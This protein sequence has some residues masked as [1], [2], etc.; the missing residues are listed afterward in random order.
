[1]YDNSYSSTRS[2]VIHA[3]D[4]HLDS[5]FLGLERYEGAPVEEIAGAT[6][7]AFENLVDFAL[8]EQAALL[9]LAGDIYDGDWPD[10]NTGLFFTRQLKRLHDGGVRVVMINGNHDAQSVITRRLPLPAN[11]TVLPHAKPETVMFEELGIAVTG[12][13]FASREITADLSQAYPPPAEGY[14]NFAVLHT[15][16]NGR[17]G[18]AG[19]APCKPAE[20]ALSGYEYWS[21]GHVHAREIISTD[22]WIVYSG[23]LQGRHARETGPKG[24]FV[25]EVADNEIDAVSPV[26]V[27]VVRW[28]VL[29]INAS[30]A[31]SIDD[32]LASF[33]ETAAE[34]V[35]QADGRLVAARVVIDGSTAAHAALARDTERLRALVCQAAI[36][37]ADAQ[38]WIEKVQL[39]TTGV[40]QITPLLGRDEPATD[41]LRVLRDFEDEETV[42]ALVE[43]VAPLRAK[44]PVELRT[45]E[46]G[47]EIGTPEHVSSLL[48]QIEVRLLGELVASEAAA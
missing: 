31:T 26:D 6:R 40:A 16:A 25:V 48:P 23:S 19:Y 10:Y 36:E 41:V 45:N 37:V 14:L 29:E 3:A 12:Q 20:L 35:S 46:N 30:Q 22:P 13:S 7:A 5:P 28:S 21:L 43:A 42:A 17:P 47:V 18:H 32:V 38:L 27:D 8:G 15:C 11:T 4:L 39:K 44:L 2:R 9:L 33:A 24:F 1:M 34:A